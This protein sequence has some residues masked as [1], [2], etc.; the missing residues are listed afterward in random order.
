[1]VHNSVQGSLQT[2]T[3]VEKSIPLGYDTVTGQAV[4]DISKDWSSFIYRVQ[5]HKKVAMMQ[6]HIPQEQIPQSHSRKK[7]STTVLVFYCKK[8][9]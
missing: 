2:C 8:R 6:H 1:M 5:R 3:I 7:H 4:P 9:C